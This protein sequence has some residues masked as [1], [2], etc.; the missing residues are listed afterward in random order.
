[1]KSKGTHDGIILHILLYLSTGTPKI[2][3]NRTQFGMEGER[4]TIEC[5]ALSVPKPDDI[6][7]FFEGRE[8]SVV[9]DQVFSWIVLRLTYNCHHY[10]SIKMFPF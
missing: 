1:M 7:W 6:S 10:S 4:V 5:A 2:I 3:S 9:H 8:I